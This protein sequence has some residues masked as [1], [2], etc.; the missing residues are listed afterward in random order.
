[1]TDKLLSKEPRTVFYVQDE[2][3]PYFGPDFR[4]ATVEDITDDMIETG[5]WAIALHGDP[6]GEPMDWDRVAAREVLEAVFR[7]D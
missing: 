5:A 6:E 7:G 2:R 1:M 3:V 4:P